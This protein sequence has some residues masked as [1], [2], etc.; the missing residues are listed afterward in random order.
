[1]LFADRSKPHAYI[2]VTS[3]SDA[4][5]TRTMLYSTCASF[6][7]P[8]NHLPMTVTRAKATAS[9]ITLDALATIDAG[10]L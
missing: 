10:S 1:M 9:Q 2:D 8:F 3:C 4:E 7:R 6:R 5:P